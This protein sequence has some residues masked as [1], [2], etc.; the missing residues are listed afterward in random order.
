MRH[1]DHD[2][3]SLA[4]SVTELSPG[5]EAARKQIDRILG[6]DTLRASD[7]L[8]R[9]LR[10]LA[11]KTFSGEA[12]DLKEYSIGLD[13]LHK[14]ANYDPRQDA[15]VRLQASRLRQKLDEYYRTEGRNDPLTVELPKGRFKIVWR[16]RMAE[17][18]PVATVVLPAVVPPV[19]QKEPTVE[20][21]ELKRWRR[22]ALCLAVVS[23]V[24][25]WVS[26]WL[27]TR[28]SRIKASNLTISK[29]TSDLEALWSPFIY[30]S[31]HLIIAFS[32]PVFVRFQRRGTPDIF[33]R[34]RGVTDWEDAV[35]S[36]EFSILSG[37]LPNAQA[38]PS[39][40]YA[41]RSELVSTFVLSQFFAGRRGD[42]S[43][44][45]LGEL[46]WQQFADNDVVLLAP[47]FRIDEKQTA[48]PVRPAFIAGEGG[49][50]NLEPR[51]GELE[52]YA[53]AH[54]HPE[55]DGETL[56][57]VSMMPGPL[58]R[59][60]VVSFTGNRAWGVIGAIQS[61]TDPAFAGTVVR[62]MRNSK[63]EMPRYYQIIIRIRYRDGTPTDAS[64]V[65]HRTLTLTENSMEAQR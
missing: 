52:V 48:L 58:G 39:F 29:L 59:T 42:I 57:L 34:R 64:Y 7:V 60:R 13:A 28:G 43:V 4:A 31:H 14:P 8:R 20:L 44:T 50:R 61:L 54:Q 23:L 37:A 32:D 6:S 22:L 49:I 38:K 11:D 17:T 55:N 26:L 40:D 10:F 12:D 36:P 2:Q 16:A 21:R 45:R 35:G 18:L 5:L 47:R 27:T 9:L 19:L 1:H 56:E 30:S 53:D 25:V 15:G 65:I 24:L 62:K 33:Y 63:G 46:S 41:V 3:T 51:A